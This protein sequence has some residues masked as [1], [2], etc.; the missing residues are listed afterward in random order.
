MWPTAEAKDYLRGLI[1]DSRDG[2]RA[3]FGKA[4]LSEILFL[5]ALLDTRKDFS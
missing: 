3:G 5:I 4:V 1:T 2:E